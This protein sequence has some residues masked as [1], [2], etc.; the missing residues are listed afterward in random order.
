[1][2]HAL[3]EG[4]DKVCLCDSKSGRISKI[5]LQSTV[6]SVLRALRCSGRAVPICVRAVILSQGCCKEALQGIGRTNLCS[7]EAFAC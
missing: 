2:K 5:I 3:W 1:M 4:G 6:E 7:W